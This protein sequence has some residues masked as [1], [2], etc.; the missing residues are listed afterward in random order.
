MEKTKK[1][2]MAIIKNYQFDSKDDQ[3]SN[4]IRPESDDLFK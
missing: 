3:I 1:S 2:P 4:L